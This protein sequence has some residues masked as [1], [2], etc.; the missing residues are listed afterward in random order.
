MLY[1]ELAC[2][3]LKTCLQPNYVYSSSLGREGRPSLLATLNHAKYPCKFS[4]ALNCL[5]A[6]AYFQTVSQSNLF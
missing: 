6:I 4:T 2:L 3:Y 1:S 5:I